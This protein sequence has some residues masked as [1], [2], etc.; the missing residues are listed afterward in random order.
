[1][2][3][4]K[5]LADNDNLFVAGETDTTFNHTAGL[6]ILKPPGR[7]KLSFAQFRDKTAERIQKIPQFGWKLHQVPGG[8][9]LP[10]WVED[11]HFDPHRHIRRIAA[12]APGNH[13]ALAEVASLIFSRRHDRRH[14]LWEIW[15]IEGLAGGRC[16]AMLK[17]HHCMMDGQGAMK[18]LEILCDLEPDAPPPKVPDSIR[19]AEPG[20]P[21]STLEEVSRGYSRL[22][23][24]TGQMSRGIV[25]QAIPMLR[26]QMIWNRPKEEK[27]FAPHALFNADIGP[28]RGYV[29]GSLPMQDIMAVKKHFGV[30]VNEV[31]LAL[32]GTALRSYMAR[33][34]SPGEY[35][36]RATMPVSLRS[37]V[38]EDFANKVTNVVVSLDTDTPDLE[39]RISTIQSESQAAKKIAHDESGGAKSAT[40]IVQ[41]M[42]PMLVHTLVSNLSAEQAANMLGS[43]LAISNVRGAPVPVYLA[44][45][46]V[47]TLYPMSVISP[48][49]ALNITCVGYVD[50]L[51]FGLTLDPDA[52][53]DSWSL[54]DDLEAALQQ[55][56][57]L[58]Q[59]VK[60]AKKK[61]AAAA[62]KARARRKKPASK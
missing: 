6:M 58:A 28:E 51:D 52:I 4:V 2:S 46:R 49:I 60:K 40:E 48:G 20:R 8:L 57:K 43:N 26:K 24:L 34:S 29:C 45:A 13:R 37:E 7:R 59:P 16:A 55:Y 1:M 35:S 15:F 3:K 14:P 44:G 36:L 11:E 38:D 21:P 30:S 50:K 18:L 5:Q 42:P 32:V 17:M 31:V 47:E 12:P 9:D 22:L 54:M 33:N 23:K 39:Q 25:S 10:Y 56:L 53:P 61:P 62:K 41:Q 27:T 19:L